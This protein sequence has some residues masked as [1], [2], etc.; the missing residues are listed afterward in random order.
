MGK[1]FNLT[2]CC[3]LALSLVGVTQ[4]TV[5]ADRSKLNPAQWTLAIYMSSDNG[6]DDWAEKDL[7]EMMMVG[8]TEA[9]NVL[10]FWDRFDG[11][12][13]AY[14]VLKGNLEELNNFELNGKEPNM[15]DPETLKK[16]VTYTTTNFPSKKYALL[17]WDHGDDFRG[18]MYDEHIPEEGFDLLTHQ[19]IVAAIKDFEIDV[20][21]YGA[22]V[23]QMIEVSYEYLVGGL[24]INYLVANEGYDPMDGYPYDI[25]LANLVKEPNM[26]PY[27]LSRM[28]VDEYINYYQYVGKAYSQAVTLSVVNIYEVGNVVY[29]LKNMT[30]AIKRDM[31]GYAPIVET[32][33]AHANLPWSEQGWERDVD[34]PTFVN[35]IYNE[36]CDPKEVYGIRPDVVRAVVSYSK[37][38]C[39][40]LNAAILYHKSLKEKIGYL[41]MGIFFPTSRDSYEND[42]HI[43]GDLYPLMAFA[44]EGWLDFLFAYWGVK[45]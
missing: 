18:A 15:G 9:V 1:T 13:H 23:M 6:L 45:K 10:V 28:C 33:R 17:L 4:A 42:R 11:P 41:G 16:W 7:D 24:K 44:K 3:F 22:C 5:A 36:S 31:R 2:V 32:A 12:A 20:M 30:A 21:L 43:Y 26:S 39:N 29:N 19:E 34:L 8:S 14:R 38:L 40:S 37:S 27:S 25:I 35:T